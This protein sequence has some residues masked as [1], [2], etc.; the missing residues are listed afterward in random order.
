MTKLYTELA[1]WWHVMSAP[2]DYAEEAA[3]CRDALE[4][5][6]AGTVE[7]LLELG[8]GGGNNASHL[9]H[10]YHLTLVEPSD[11]MRARSEELNPECRHLPGDMRTV[12]LD[13][14]FDAVFVHDAIGYM[15]TE[16]DLR[17]A[18]R[19]A[20]LHCRPGGVAL[21]VPDYT[22]ETWRGGVSSGGHDRGERSLRY[23]Q[24]VYDPDP[25]DTCFTTAFAF[26][27]KE[28]AGQV[29]AESDEHVMGLFPKAM[30]LSLLR[31]AGFEPLTRPHRH[32]SFDTE[33]GRELFL[34]LRPA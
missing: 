27:L 6:G 21:F 26:L 8:S 22:R 25:D 34:G 29:R 20:Y 23:L 4:D 1:E 13:K 12:R 17:A 15:T 2:A 3:L 16:S 7:T 5:S 32:S 31:D 24:W 14:T 9:K 30:W 19:T 10:H 28:G 33:E 18:I 11:R